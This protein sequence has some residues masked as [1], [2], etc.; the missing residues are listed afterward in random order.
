MTRFSPEAGPCGSMLAVARSA[1]GAYQSDVH[2]HTLPCMSANPHGLSGYVPTPEGDLLLKFA[3][4]V[5]SVSPVE[6]APVV[7][8]RHA[9]SH[10]ASLGSRYRT[11]AAG[12]AFSF[13]MNCSTSRNVTLSTGQR[14]PQSTKWLGAVPITFRHSACVTS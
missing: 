8:A 9:Y 3:F 4:A 1:Y 2:S 13:A 12:F 5:E 11:V 14:G 10:S 6:N 7:P